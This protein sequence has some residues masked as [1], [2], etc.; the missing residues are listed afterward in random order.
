MVVERVNIEAFSTTLEEERSIEGYYT[1]IYF[2]EEK[3]VCA[4]FL[5]IIL[6]LTK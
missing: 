4:F 6:P 2:H 1:N 3:V 5:S